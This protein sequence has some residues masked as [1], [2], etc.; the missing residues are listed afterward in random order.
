MTLRIPFTLQYVLMRLYSHMHGLVNN[1]H[2]ESIACTYSYSCMQIPAPLCQS[3]IQ[4]I[5][6]TALLESK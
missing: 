5:S 6:F 1:K 3:T 2:L 4:V